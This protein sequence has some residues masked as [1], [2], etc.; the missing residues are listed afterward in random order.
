MV[1]TARD[2]RC[3]N[4]MQQQQQETVTPAVTATPHSAL[5]IAFC[6]GRL[7]YPIL[8]YKVDLTKNRIRYTLV[9]FYQLY[10][11]DSLFK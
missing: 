8:V 5:V 6:C 2:L 7:G 9:I 3:R 1:E 4:S 10:R 11:R